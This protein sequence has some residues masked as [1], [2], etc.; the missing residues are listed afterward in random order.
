MVSSAFNIK[1]LTIGGEV[2]CLTLIIVLG[3]V[4]GGL[5]LD[6]LFNTKP[7][8]T[9]ALVLASAPI[10]LMLTFWIATRAIKDLQPPS[11]TNQGSPDKLTQGDDNQ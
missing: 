10:S 2:G 8:I 9:V 11:K 3:S 5:W 6:R 4:F 7:M 1:T